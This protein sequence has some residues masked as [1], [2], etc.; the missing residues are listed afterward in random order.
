[1]KYI[2]FCIKKLSTESKVCKNTGNSKLSTSSYSQFIV[3]EYEYKRW[4]ELKEYEKDDFHTNF[5]K[6]LSKTLP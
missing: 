1:M 2:L 4:Y 6:E 3:E 5:C